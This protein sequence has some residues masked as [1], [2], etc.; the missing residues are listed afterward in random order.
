MTQYI[1]RRVLGMIPLLII[2]SMFI[3]VLIQLPPGTYVDALIIE[4]E[5]QGQEV[6]REQVDALKARYGLDAPLYMQYWRWVSGFPRGDF[7]VSFLFWGKSNIEIIGTYLGWTVL[8]AVSTQIF[9]LLAGIPI[10]VYSATHKYSLGDNFF[11]FLGFVGLSIPNFLLALILMFV[12][13]FVFGIPALGGLFSNQYLDEPWSVGKFVDLLQH[14]WIPIV[15]LGTAGAAGIIRRMRGNLLDVLNM[16]YISTARAKGLRESIV[17][18]KH[19]VKNALAPIIMA[20]GMW[21][22]D[23]LSGSV[24]VSIVLS[25]P[26]LG[27]VLYRALLLQDMYLA[28][29]ILFFQSVLLLMGNLIADLCLAWV[30]PRVEYD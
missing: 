26:T 28:G 20:V 15:V 21:F 3:F 10:G 16:Q 23:I 24:I 18:H 14:L 17:I 22:P 29:T 6:S 1:I 5:S 8:L 12:A 9:I 2:L 27:P 7:G 4:L 11:T 13:Y 25:L 30:D 19:A